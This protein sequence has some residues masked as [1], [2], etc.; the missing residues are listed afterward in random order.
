MVKS[1]VTKIIEQNVSNPAMD[2]ST[3]VNETF[4]LD[5]KILP[6]IEDLKTNSKNF[7]NMMRI[8]LRSHKTL[9]I[10]IL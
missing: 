4:L 3:T 10:E 1:K 9:Q 7:I 5:K 2:T 8:C 6:D